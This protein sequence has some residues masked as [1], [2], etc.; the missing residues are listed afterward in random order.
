MKESFGDFVNLTLAGE[1]HG[2]AILAVLSGFPAGLSVSGEQIAAVLSRRRPAEKIGTARREED[3]FEILSG[4]FNGKT[5]GAPIAFLLP[6]NDFD[7]LPYEEEREKAR[8]SHADYTAFVQSGGYNDY[9]GGGRFSGR[10][11]VGLAAAGALAIE[12]LRQKGIKI[13][14][15]IAFCG[16]VSDRA[17]ENYEED[18][19]ALSEKGFAVLS[20]EAE[21][22][23]KEAIEAAAR[24]GDSVGGILETAVTGVPAGLG[25]PWFDSVE[26]RLSHLLFSIPAVKGVEFGDGFA[27]ANSRGSQMND[28]FCIKD[29]KIYTESNH[30][31]GVNGGITN[32]MPLVFRTVIKPTPSLAKE[33]KTVNFLTGEE[34][35]VAIHGRHD[36]AI[37][38]RA[39]VLMDA[40]AALVLCDFMSRRFGENW[41]SGETV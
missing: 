28:P 41:L 7:D 22:A 38:A 31:G 17:F 8:P 32:G 29:D 4:V 13:G 23:M 34:T 5:T 25:A 11:T 26:S 40:A 10:L 20:Q 39:A 2:K 1:S 15:H 24:D 35:T 16:G 27:M 30:N 18:F 9:R 12:A 21:K 33:Q 3:K 36:P 19:A 6:N 14:T 37:A